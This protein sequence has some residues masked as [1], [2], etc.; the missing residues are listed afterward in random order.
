MI[1][2][3]K[4]L[5]IKLY[6][7]FSYYKDSFLCKYIY[8]NYHNYTCYTERFGYID[9]SECTRCGDIVEPF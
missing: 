1:N 6:L 4:C 3:I 9:Y 7:W 5:F 2:Y 8:H